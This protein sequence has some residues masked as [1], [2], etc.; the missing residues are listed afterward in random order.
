MSTFADLSAAAY[1]P[2]KLY[3]RRREEGF[4]IPETVRAKRRLAFRYR[5]L[6]DPDSDLSGEPIAVTPTQYRANLGCLR[7]RDAWGLLAE[8]DRTEVLLE[9]KDARGIAQKVDD[10]P[11]AVS[12]VSAGE[13]PETGVWAPQSVR[14]VAAAKALAWE[15]G[16][17]VERAY[18]EYP[19]HGLVRTVELTTR[20]K[21]RYREAL[22]RAES[23]D[24]P[25]SR[26]D[27]DAKCD[28]CEYRSTCGTKTRSL[29]SLL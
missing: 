12:V 15:L 6:T 23:I 19:A 9:G 27:N 29:R 17:S 2:R 18:V 3:Y 8:P 21:A 22:A 10:A 14:A 20:R 28:A 16:E 24:E 5:E 7:E 13:P 11:P 4:E 25:P 26:I 1:C